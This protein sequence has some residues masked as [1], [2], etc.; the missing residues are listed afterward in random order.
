ML[1]HI[2]ESP[3]TEAVEREAFGLKEF[4]AGIN[5]TVEYVFLLDKI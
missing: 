4:A 2:Q 3:S 1:D 5:P